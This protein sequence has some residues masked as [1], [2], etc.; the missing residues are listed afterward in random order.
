MPKLFDSHENFAEWFSKDIEANSSKGSGKL[1]SKHVERLHKVLKPF[2]LRRVKSDV[3]NELGPKFE[4]DIK[5][6]MT[7][8]QKSFY[9]KLRPTT[10]ILNIR[11]GDNFDSLMN[12]VM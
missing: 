9:N 10:D 5:C 2:M 8:R 11:A 1:D 3:E 4:V 6:E 12:I 7:Y